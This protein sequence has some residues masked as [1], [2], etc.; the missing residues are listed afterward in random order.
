MMTKKPRTLSYKGR[1]LPWVLLTA[2]LIPVNAQNAWAIGGLGNL[3]ESRILWVETRT[4]QSLQSLK[5]FFRA[6][7]Q[8]DD[9]YGTPVLPVE[10]S[11]SQ[12]PPAAPPSVSELNMSATEGMGEALGGIAETPEEEAIG[13]GIHRM[14]YE[15]SPEGAI[16]LGADTQGHIYQV[17]LSIHKDL[18]YLL[19][20]QSS[21]TGIEGHVIDLAHERDLEDQKIIE[22]QLPSW[23]MLR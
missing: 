9:F 11:V 21:S 16:R 6:K 1:S 22:N 20:E 10:P 19:K 13:Q 4:M 7:D 17:L 14:A 5:N 2:F 18:L 23:I 15:A 8:G 12:T 3:L